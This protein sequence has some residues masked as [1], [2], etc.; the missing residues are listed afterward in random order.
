MDRT[1][2]GWLSS[3]SVLR[4][5]RRTTARGLGGS[6]DSAAAAWHRRLAAILKAAAWR[7]SLLAN[8][9]E[10][11]AAAYL[12]AILASAW[13]GRAYA[14]VMAALVAVAP[15]AHRC[16]RGERGVLLSGVA[17]TWLPRR[18]N[19]RPASLP[20]PSRLQRRVLLCGV[21]RARFL[22]LS[23]ARKTARFFGRF[24]AI[25]HKHGACSAFI[26]PRHLYIRCGVT[27]SV[28]HHLRLERLAVCRTRFPPK[29]TGC[30][31]LPGH[32][33]TWRRGFAAICT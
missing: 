5:T 29:T 16:D 12:A 22:P 19:W 15:S 18:S 13:R 17:A 6:R 1:W 24:G 30:C 8:G 11:G 32:R 28:I 21:Q 33:T 26:S 14:G 4:K 7:N 20:P 25:R 2:R 3:A 9:G 23:G 27:A 31:L 10:G